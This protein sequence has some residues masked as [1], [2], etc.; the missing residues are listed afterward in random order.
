MVNC[1]GLNSGSV[2][3]GYQEVQKAIGLM[4]WYMLIKFALMG[5]SAVIKILRNIF[6]KICFDRHTLLVALLTLLFVYLVYCT[7]LP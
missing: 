3:F 1:E 4:Q 6:R 5:Q 2:C 7:L